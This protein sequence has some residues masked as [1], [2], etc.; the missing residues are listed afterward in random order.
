MGNEFNLNNVKLIEVSDDFLTLD[1]TTIKCQNS[2]NLQDC[3]TRK[4]VDA[5]KK[6]CKCLPFGIRDDEDKVISFVS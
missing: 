1:K 4:Y 5:I 2:E 6:N 3:K